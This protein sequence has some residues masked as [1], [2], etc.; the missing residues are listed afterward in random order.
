MFLPVGFHWDVVAAYAFKLLD[1]IF[2]YAKKWKQKHSEDE[3][4]IKIL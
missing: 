2:I 4:G 3:L 1:L